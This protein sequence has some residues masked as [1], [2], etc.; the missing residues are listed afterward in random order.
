MTCNDMNSIPPALIRPGRIYVKLHMGYLGNY[1]AKLVFWRSFCTQEKDTSLEIMPTKKYPTLAKTVD[2]LIQ[3][4]RD[5]AHKVS[6]ERNVPLEISP[7]ELISYF[8]F[9]AFKF[10]LS[11][12]PQHIDLCCQ[13]ILDH[14]FDLINSVAI[15]RK[16]A[17]E[18]AK[19]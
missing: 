5:E 17:V 2:E 10:K 8:L 11:T 3:R 19:K 18:Y 15:D 4:M 13:S 16:Q 7:V 14:I 12:Q 1:Q 6:L 9:H